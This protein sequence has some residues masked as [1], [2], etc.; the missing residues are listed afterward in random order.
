MIKR[1]MHGV[2]DDENDGDGTN[3]HQ[4]PSAEHGTERKDNEEGAYQ[5]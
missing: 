4:E 1:R 2:A 3:V 5:F